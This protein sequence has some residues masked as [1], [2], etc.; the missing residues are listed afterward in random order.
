MASERQRILVPLDGSRLAEAVLPTAIGFAARLGAELTLLHV[1]EQKPPQTVHGEPHLRG[2]EEAESYLERVEQ[3][4]RGEG[5]AVR[6]HVHPNPIRDVAAS[7]AGHAAELRAALIA[8][9]THGSGGVRELIAGSIAEQTLRQGTTSVLL[10]RPTREGD[11]P[12]F[13]CRHLR[14]ALETAEHGTAALRAALSLA[15]ACDAYVELVTVVPTRATLPPGR[16]AAG[17]LSPGAMA[18]VLD[19]ERVDVADTLARMAESLREAGVRAG[20]EVRRGDPFTEVQHLLR[21]TPTD[22][23]VVATHARAGLGAWLA[24]SFAPRIVAACAVPV[25]LVRTTGP[26]E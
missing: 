26:E 16:R 14:V 21:E 18:A 13:R 2:R 20:V 8:T 12:S 11:A 7:I 3:R 10:V 22:L 25:L 5:V 19:L 1:L 17:A 15:R 6:H 24:A 9:S 4:C 23:L